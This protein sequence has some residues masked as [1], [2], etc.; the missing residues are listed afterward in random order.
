MW[1][2][3]KDIKKSNESVD[4]TYVAWDRNTS[5]TLVKQK[6]NSEFYKILV[7]S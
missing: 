7:I 2:Y 3:V 1:V 4:W 6:M 5:R